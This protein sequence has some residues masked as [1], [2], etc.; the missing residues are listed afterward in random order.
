MSRC[1]AVLSHSPFSAVDSIEN[2]YAKPS[3]ETTNN[4][5]SSELNVA[6]KGM[7]GVTLQILLLHTDEKYFGKKSLIKDTL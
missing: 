4:C 2:V 5:L 1:I 3:L 7:S 6:E